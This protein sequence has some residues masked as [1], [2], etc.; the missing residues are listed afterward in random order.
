LVDAGPTGKQSR[1]KR[2][3]DVMASFFQ[4]VPVEQYKV[5][6]VAVYSGAKPVVS[7]THDLEVVNNILDDLP[8][9]HAFKA[10]ETDIFAGLNEAAKLAQP[11]RPKSTTV[12]LL[13]D[14]DSVPAVG[15]PKMPASVAHVVIV[16]VGDPRVGRFINGRNSRQDAST[17]RQVAVRLNGRY[18]D[19]NEKQLP[20]TLLQEL[21]QSAEASPFELTRREYALIA[22]ALGSAVLALLPLLLALFGTRWRPGHQPL[23]AAAE[24]PL[25]RAEISEVVGAS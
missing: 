12:M 13:S 15:M 3:A 16:G 25:R 17:L 2:V 20:T 22:C 1:R 14:G 21:T 18:H 11:W 4:R 10:G 7:D 5:S 8:M 23:V 6:V 9:E 24:K 19:A